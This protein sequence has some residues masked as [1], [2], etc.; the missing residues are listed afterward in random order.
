MTARTITDVN[1]LLLLSKCIANQYAK[2][3]HH[4][5]QTQEELALSEILIKKSKFYVTL[6]FDFKVISVILMSKLLYT[7]N[8][9]FLWKI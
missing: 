7:S 8:R 3:K 6:I 4:L 5:S 2:C 1:C 9:Q